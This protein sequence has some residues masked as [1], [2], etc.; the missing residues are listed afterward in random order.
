MSFLFEKIYNKFLFH[1][2]HPNSWAPFKSNRNLHKC[3]AADH[4]EPNKC[5]ARLR[6]MIF[7]CPP[8]VR[9]NHDEPNNRS[10]IKKQSFSREMKPT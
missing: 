10:M 4:D 6:Y 1:P 8:E 7:S 9:D 3:L 5:L 2:L